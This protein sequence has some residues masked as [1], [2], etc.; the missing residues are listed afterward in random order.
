MGR[1]CFFAVLILLLSCKTSNKESDEAFVGRPNIVLILADDMGYSDLGSY[2]GEISTP[3][4][5]SLAYGGIRFTNFYNAARCCPTRAS[6]LTGVY[7][8]QAGV[9]RM[10]Y[11][12]YGGAYQGF[13]NRTSVTLAEVL[14][15][16]GYKTMMSGKWHVGHKESQQWPT[17]RGFDRF[18]GINIHVDSYW[19]VLKNC[20]VYLDGKLHIPATDDPKNDLHP[21]QDWYT[22]DVFTDYGIHFLNQEVAEAQ[23]GDRPF[24]LYMAYN[25]PHFPLEAPDDDIAKYQGRYMEGW[26]KL[27]EEKHRRMKEMGIVP[28]H[29]ILSPPDNV[30]WDSLSIED[31]ENLDFRRAIYAAQ[32]DRMDQN[33]G[34]LVAHLKQIGEYENTLIL[35]LSDNGC[36]AE[37]DMFG[38][39]WDKYKRHNYEVWKEESG[40]SVSQGQAWANVSNVPFRRYKRYTHEGG[41]ATPLIAHWPK[42]IQTG[43]GINTDTGHIVDIMATLV[44]VAEAD[45][46]Q[47]YNGNQITSLEGKSLLPLLENDQ[48]EGHQ[49]IFWEHLGHRAV[50]KGDWKLV[51]VNAQPWELYHLGEDPT[52]LNNLVDERPESVEE[53]QKAYFAWA[54]K[55]GVREVPLKK[56]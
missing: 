19:K 1:A 30:K 17:G 35:F 41:T 42:K 25:A 44:E 36:S 56:E 40:W 3:N 28:P 14:K 34:R 15:E 8:H 54:E 22:T 53:L 26:D 9:G 18:Y 12:D 48:R 43:G 51:A 24:F 27:R 4:I 32:I 5:D 52:E 45:Y 7:P 29:T 16:A 10:V 55:T 39:N 21:E 33:I 47:Q 13:L 11:G 38:M 23:D 2:G 37:T 31:R 6:L 46:P 20:D 50:R 49:Y